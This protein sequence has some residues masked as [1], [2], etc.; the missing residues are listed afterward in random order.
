MGHAAP[1]PQLEAAD[2]R[3]VTVLI[4][5]WQL[6]DDEDAERLRYLESV[7][8]ETTGRIAAR[9]GGVVG[10]A[11][12]GRVTVWFGSPVAHEDDPKRAVEAALQLIESARVDLQLVPAVGIATGE[13]IAEPGAGPTHTGSMF[14]STVEQARVLASEA[15]VC[16]VLLNRLAEQLVGSRFVAQSIQTT[17]LTDA[18]Q[19]VGRRHDPMPRAATP[20]VGRDRELAYLIGALEHATRGHGLAITIVGEPGVGKTRLAAELRARTPADSL[21]LVARCASFEVQEPFALVAQLLRGAF[22]IRGDADE[23]TARSVITSGL[24][25]FEQSEAHTSLLLNLLGYRDDFLIAPAN[26]GRVL[27]GLLRNLLVRASERAP[28]LVLIEDVQWADATSIGVLAE[29]SR[30]L[31]KLACLLLATARPGVAP[32]WPAEQ[33]QL[34]PLSAESSEDLA[35]ILIRTTGPSDRALVRKLVVRGAGNPFFIEELAM[36]VPL[37]A[38]A[39]L[40]SVPPTVQGVLQA[41]LDE[42]SDEVK[43]VLSLAATCGRTVRA[44][45]LERLAPSLDV[46]GALVDLVRE[47]VLVSVVDQPEAFTFRHALLQE[48]AYQRL[49]RSQRVDAH[50]AIAAG[51]EALYEGRVDEVLGELAFH[52]SRAENDTKAVEFLVRAAD[53]ASALFA[54]DEA[55]SLYDQALA[56]ALRGEGPLQTVEI[57]ESIG[58]VRERISRFDDA[59]AAFQ[60]AL[61]QL[62]A[63]SGP[64]AARLHRRIGTSLLSKGAYV[65]ATTAIERGLELLEPDQRRER[66]RLLNQLGLAYHRR[67]ICG[68][69]AELLIAAGDLCSGLDEDRDILA[70][71]KLLLGPVLMDTLNLE[72]ARRVLDDCLALYEVLEDLTGIAFARTDLGVIYRRQGN[73]SAALAQYE[74]VL[75]LRERVGDLWGLAVA[76]NNIGEVLCS[77]GAYIEAIPAYERAFE[78]W[79]GMNARALAAIA[80]VGM[81]DARIGLQQPAQAREL[82]VR[83]EELFAEVATTQFLPYVHR[84]HALVELCYGN[85]DAARHAVDR[86]IESSR[87]AGVRSQ[88]ALSQRVLA[89]V[90]AAQGDSNEAARLLEHSDRV[91]AEL[92]ETGDVDLIDG[93]R[94][95]AHRARNSS[96]VGAV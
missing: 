42:F 57:L 75:P 69:A 89:D 32:A 35:S 2:R 17:E 90:Y 29:L 28:L 87:A 70:E 33:L 43:S 38:S 5:E 92:G 15:G 82:L 1:H 4:A 54:N 37:H 95:A 9:F 67:G 26:R 76:N 56:R 83:A 94:A 55:L 20:F 93:M 24:A 12:T 80:L 86:A 71:T 60:T 31:P 74:A 3:L 62:S 59:V 13:V 36:A 48:V 61:E 91:L 77:Q 18:Y 52:Y 68:V 16:Q 65:E 10:K 53:R 25:D 47:S 8:L 51:L 23:A 41:R 45:L 46:S 72:A 21:Q 6:L 64:T 39:S 14:G 96:E 85:L 63:A 22:A 84:G 88:E 40:D 58:L 66:A 7:V 30:E 50:A 78:M 19:L 11:Q 44:A 49:L 73:W 81:A 27:L 79:D 34:K